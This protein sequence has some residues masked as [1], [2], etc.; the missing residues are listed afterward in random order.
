MDFVELGGVRLAA[1]RKMPLLQYGVGGIE[2]G[3]HAVGMDWS[4]EFTGSRGQI[5]LF[6]DILS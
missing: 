4:V 6:H 3:R 5:M 2:R 1:R